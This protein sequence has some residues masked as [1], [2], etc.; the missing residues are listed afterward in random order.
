MQSTLPIR[1]RGVREYS[2]AFGVIFV[3]LPSEKT[4]QSLKRKHNKVFSTKLTFGSS[5]LQNENGL[6]FLWTEEC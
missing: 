5:T 6:E 3:F 4:I 2:V 1:V